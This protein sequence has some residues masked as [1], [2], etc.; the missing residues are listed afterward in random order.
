[1]EWGTQ[2]QNMEDARRHGTLAVGERNGGA[3]LA[4]GDVTRA[5]KLL[6]G[7]LTITAVAKMLGV[8]RDTVGKIKR[9]ERWRCLER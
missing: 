9:G 5:I 2:K 1:L 3:K 4:S 7:G 6:A 8:A